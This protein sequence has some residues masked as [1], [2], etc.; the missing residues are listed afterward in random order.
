[1]DELVG[2]SSKKRLQLAKNKKSASPGRCGWALGVV[3]GGSVYSFNLYSRYG[4]ISQT[5]TLIRAS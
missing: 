4:F 2:F 3:P 5:T 1:M